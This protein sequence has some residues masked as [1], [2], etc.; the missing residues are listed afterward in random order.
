MSLLKKVP[1]DVKALWKQANKVRLNT[2]AI[3]EGQVYTLTVNGV[4]D[5]AAPANTIAA[6][7]QRT[8]LQTQGGLTRREFHDIGGTL[9]S[10]LTNHAKFTGNQPDATAFATSLETPVNVRENYGVQFVGYVTAPHT[11]DYTFYVNSDDQGALF[12]STDDSPA[13]KVQIAREPEWNGS[14][15]WT[16]TDRRPGQA[17]ISAPLHLEAGHRYYLEA[18]MK[19]G[20]GGDNL[21]VTWRIPG[22]PAV[23]N[24]AEPIPGDFLSGVE[25][26]TPVTITAQPQSQTIGE[27][28]P[29]T[30]NVALAGTPAYDYQWFR[31]G[32]MIV[33]AN[34]PHYTI[35]SVQVADSGAIFHVLTGNG[36]SS[37]LS[38]DAV[39]S[40]TADTTPPAIVSVQS[41]FNGD[42]VIVRFSEPMN[43]GDA[44]DTS[45]YSLNGGVA[46]SAA[47]LSTDGRTVTLTTSAQTPGTSYTLTVTGLRDTA[48][49][50]NVI[51]PGSQITFNALVL[52]R[53][54]LRREVWLGIPGNKLA[55]LTNDPRFP[56]SPDAVSHVTFAESPASLGDNYGARL[57]GFLLPPVTGDYVFYLASDDEGG[58]F[59]STDETP[60]NLQSVAAEPERSGQRQWTDSV[61]QGSRGNPPVN[62]S[63]PIHLEAGQR[64]YVEAL[65]K[66]ASSG[67]HLAVAWQKPG[68]PVPEN[69]SEPIPGTYLA[70]YADPT[71]VAI[72]VTE[73]P[74]DATVTDHQTATFTVLTTG[75]TRERFFTKESS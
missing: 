12:L 22:G 40:V 21:A 27:R 71:G 23:T 63:A 11:G 64:Y 9:L 20:G 24:G 60:G 61:N 6:N 46:I 75:S 36:I 58:L 72:A 59:L 7:T 51:A 32:Q 56:Y 14:R 68:D 2:T 65:M 54:F 13:N 49:T 8:F 57:R 48:A 50:P 62:I 67:D 37:I 16:A 47:S 29:V 4:Q 18:L 53:G 42:Q 44:T 55:D 3:A 30:F 5:T 39:L 45:H 19:E 10:D 34:G 28:D 73:P 33:G 15:N 26:L 74:H 38:T 31:N 69:F 43:A 17:N 41:V 66:E 1:A 70:T 25:P 52:T 35:P